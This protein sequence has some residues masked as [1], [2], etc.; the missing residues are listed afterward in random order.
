MSEIKT[1]LL[2]VSGRRFANTITYANKESFFTS[3]YFLKKAFVNIA[4]GLNNVLYSLAACAH[5]LRKTDRQCKLFT[6]VSLPV[7][8]ACAI[9]SFSE[10]YIELYN[11]ETF[12][13]DIN[14]MITQSGILPPYFF[15]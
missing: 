8:T 1:F 2:S 4:G 12:E 6:S 5:L 10:K 3:V 9:I 14:S 11:L 7:P 15:L 13:K